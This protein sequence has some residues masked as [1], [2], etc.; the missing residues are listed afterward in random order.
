MGEDRV[1]LQVLSLREAV[2][3]SVRRC[4]ELSGKLSGIESESVRSIITRLQALLSILYNKVGLETKKT[5]PVLRDSLEKSIDLYDSLSKAVEGVEGIEKVEEDLKKLEDTVEKLLEV[6]SKVESNLKSLRKRLIVTSFLLLFSSAYILALTTL[7]NVRGL[8]SIKGAFSVTLISLM[9]LSVL[10]TLQNYKYTNFSLTI[11]LPT[12]TTSILILSPTKLPVILQLGLVIAIV[13][14][15][16]TAYY[17]LKWNLESWTPSL[18]VELEFKRVKP[19]RRRVKVVERALEEPPEDLVERV[20]E[21]YTK[22]YGSVGVEILKYEI[23]NLREKGVSLKE[24]Y[25]EVAKR[26]GLKVE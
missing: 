20:K 5:T 15:L 18:R 8:S 23:R 11:L 26:I 7:S 9:A 16:A 19:V 6:H 12:S 4:L 13:S 10:A 25:L 14:L 3:I 21:A 24:A 1:K 22:R 2:L 17:G